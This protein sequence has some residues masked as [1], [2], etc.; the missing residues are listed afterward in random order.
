[1]YEWI[2]FFV[3]EQLLIIIVHIM[4]IFN[5]LQIFAI[6]DICGIFK[7]KLNEMFGEI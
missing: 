4:L 3:Y 2:G 5:F 7:C 1:M 6:T